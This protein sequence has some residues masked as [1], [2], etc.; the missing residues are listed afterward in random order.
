MLACTRC[1]YDT[2]K[3]LLSKFDY[4]K[5]VCLTKRQN[6]NNEGFALV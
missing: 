1:R 5:E 6:N 3:L 4:M 2:A